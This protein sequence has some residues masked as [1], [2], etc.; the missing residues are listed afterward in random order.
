VNRRSAPEPAAATPERLQK[1]L[2]RAGLASRRE[3]EE[4]IRAGRVTV[5]SEV[6]TLGSRALGNDQI[7]LDGKLVRQASTLRSASYLCHR[8][9]GESLAQPREGD[10]RETMAERL[11]RRVGRRYIAI[12]PMPRIDGGL[13]LL[14]SDGELAVRLQRLVRTLL[15]NFSVRIRG[16]LGAPQIAGILA[17]ELDSGSRLNILACEP[18]GGE[19]ANRWYQLATVGANGRELRSLIERQGATVSRVMRISLG[20][21]DLDRSVSRGQMR[22]LDEDDIAKLLAPQVAGSGVRSVAELPEIDL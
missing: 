8:S 11:P 15:T 6:A 2:A 16:E 7:R 18:S 12:S 21:L 1:I 4:W 14:T 19:A 13:E 22:L 9:P 10:D 17:G 3:A 5:N 20:G